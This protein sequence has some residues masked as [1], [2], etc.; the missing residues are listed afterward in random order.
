MKKAKKAHKLP[1]TLSLIRSAA[2]SALCGIIC[3]FVLLMLLAAL[4]M[5][6]PSP[7]SLLLP[8]SLAAIYLSSFATGI[9]SGLCT[10]RGERLLSS[11]LGGTLFTLMLS[12][13]LIP[14][15]NGGEGAHFLLKFLGIPL[16]LLGGICA[17]SRSNRKK[18][19]K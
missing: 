4:S 12:L 18:R 1:P 15:G 17:P 14:F 16:A 2:I 8:V 7:H 11:L 6:A 5:L 19:R 3:F 13:V 9:V 10:E